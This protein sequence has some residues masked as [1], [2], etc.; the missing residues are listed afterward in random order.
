MVKM[1]SATLDQENTYRADADAWMAMLA[2]LTPA[3]EGV[4]LQRLADATGMSLGDVQAQWDALRPGD[5]PTGAIRRVVQFFK[6]RGPSALDH[7][8]PGH[9]P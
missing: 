9:E 1:T 4:F 6:R 5:V 8:P 7:R 2:G 3:D